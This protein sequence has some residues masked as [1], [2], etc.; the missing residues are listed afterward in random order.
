MGGSTA[1]FH[2]PTIDIAPY[3]KDPTSEAAD[4]IIQDVRN[5]CMAVGFFS[6][7][8]HSVSR[9]VQ[10]DVFDAAKKL[11]SLPIEEK[12]ALRHPLLKNRG[13][14]IIGGQALQVDTLP[15]L[16]EVSQYLQ[17]MRDPML[18]KV[19]SQHTGFLYWPAH[20]R[21][22]SSGPSTSAPTG[23]EHLSSQPLPI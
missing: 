22:F 3:L 23:R 18:I 16:K 8:G 20:T 6:L 1:A 9:K 17:S 15:D 13:Y 5:A 2:I 7:V 21:A 11:F 14:E 10:D 4:Q 12:R 19:W